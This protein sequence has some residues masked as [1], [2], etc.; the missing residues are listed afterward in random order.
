M[1]H[2]HHS[3]MR[4]LIARIHVPPVAAA[5]SSCVR[6]CFRHAGAKCCQLRQLT[7]SGLRLAP[8]AAP[9]SLQ[10]TSPCPQSAGRQTTAVSP[11]RMQTRGSRRPR[12]RAPLQQ[13]CSSRYAAGAWSLWTPSTLAPWTPAS[14]LARRTCR[15]V[16]AV[17]RPLPL[18][19]CFPLY[20]RLT[21]EP[22]QSGLLDLGAPCVSWKT[23]PCLCFCSQVQ[24]LPGTQT[25]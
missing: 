23:C 22:Y 20:Q 24:S 10:H 4:L 9:T 15:Q 3:P 8:A 13:P 17:A 6:T 12:R 5:L 11:C 2:Q 7:R 14:C 19:L 18:H 25:A 21:R 16:P 1:A